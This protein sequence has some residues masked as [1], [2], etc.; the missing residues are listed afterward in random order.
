MSRPSAQPDADHPL[1]AGIL[2]LPILGLAL[3]LLG[4]LGLRAFAPVHA[5]GPWP[6]AGLALAS[7]LP[8]G[9]LLIR[10][11]RKV[12]KELDELMQRVLLEGIAIGA[13]AFLLLQ[14]LTLNFLAAGTLPWS[15]DPPE[16]LLT[17]ILCVGLGIAW[18]WRGYR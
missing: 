17:P 15:L 1:V 9:L 14:A 2:A 18:R 4:N 3:A 12:T 8:L 11:Q 7:V 5:L 6:R 10:F 16:L 13:G